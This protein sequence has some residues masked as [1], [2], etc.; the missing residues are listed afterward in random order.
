M[1]KAVRIV[2]KGTLCNAELN[3]S[4][5][6]HSVHAKPSG[7]RVFMRFGELPPDGKSRNHYLQK[8][9]SGV[10]V[11]NAWL[12]GGS[13]VPDIQSSGQLHSI[14]AL[15][16]RQGP[17]YLVTGTP[18]GKGGDNE[19]VLRDARIVGDIVAEI[20]DHVVFYTLRGRRDAHEKLI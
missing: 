18:V 5:K 15:A 7:V 19:P 13:I 9:E 8:T 16:R 11:F 20:R 6:V 12:S 4:I 10:S 2:F 14:Q 3:G 17:A 1:P